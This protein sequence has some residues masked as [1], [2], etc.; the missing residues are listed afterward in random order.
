[1][2]AMKKKGRP[3]GRAYDKPYAFRLSEEQRKQLELISRHQ[4]KT[5][6]DYLREMIQKEYYRIKGDRLNNEDQ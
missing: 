5:K 1:M 4:E 3:Y 6:Q 2:N